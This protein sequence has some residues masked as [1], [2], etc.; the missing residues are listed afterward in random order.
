MNFLQSSGSNNTNDQSSQSD[1]N[2]Q[3]GYKCE[4]CD[5]ISKTFPTYVAPPPRT[6]DNVFI[7]N[8]Y[9][10]YYRDFARNRDILISTN[11][12][13]EDVN[14][15]LPVDCS[16]LFWEDQQELIC[17]GIKEIEVPGYNQE[18]NFELFKDKIDRA[19]ESNNYKVKEKIE[20]I[21]KNK[22]YTN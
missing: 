20:E 19:V 7:K 16:S 18:V 2:N 15:K 1:Q 9:Q 14:R 5:H 11:T 17:Q 21:I 3:S 6:L 13:G 10:N 22:M 4:N 12:R 8:N